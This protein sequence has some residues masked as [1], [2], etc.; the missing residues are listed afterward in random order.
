[1]A[2]PRWAQFL[3]I[4]CPGNRPHGQPSCRDHHGPDGRRALDA[5]QECHLCHWSGESPAF[6]Q[7]VTRTSVP[8]SPSSPVGIHLVEEIPDHGHKAFSDYDVFRNH[9]IPFL[10]L[11]AARSPCYHTAGDVAST[12]HY[13][14]MAATVEWLRQP[15]HR[16]GRTRP[17]IHSTRIEWSSP[18]KS[19]HS[20]ASRSRRFTSTHSYRE[21]HAGR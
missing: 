21:R 16:W 4:T 9:Q 17:Y 10:F 8:S 2:P 14:R 19:P 5:A 18:M 12:L 7:H 13:D 3:F 11:S 1:M 15:W 20:A 6:Y